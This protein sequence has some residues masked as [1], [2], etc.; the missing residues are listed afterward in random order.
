M[1][2][3]KF[4]TVKTFKLILSSKYWHFSCK[5]LVGTILAIFVLKK[6]SQIY[7]EIAYYFKFFKSSITIIL[8]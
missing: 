1:F 7:S 3:F 4:S 8:Y 2:K 6:L 5:C